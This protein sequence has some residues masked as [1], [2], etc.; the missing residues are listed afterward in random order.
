[1]MPVALRPDEAGASSASPHP[2]VKVCRARG[3]EGEGERWA[4]EQVHPTLNAFDGACETRLVCA[5]VHRQEV[6]Q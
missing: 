5:V 2:F 3:P 4:A 1:M 6:A